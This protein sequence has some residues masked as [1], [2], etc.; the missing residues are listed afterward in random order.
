MC[1]L[2]LQCPSEHNKSDARSQNYTSLYNVSKHHKNDQLLNCQTGKL[3]NLE[4][5]WIE[6]I[7]NLTKTRK[8]YPQNYAK[9]FEFWMHCVNLDVQIEQ[10]KS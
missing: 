8:M 3:S 1:E 6:I 4:V 2:I 9:K 5:I 7:S 10:P